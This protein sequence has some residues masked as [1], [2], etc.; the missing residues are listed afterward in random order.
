[1]NTTVFTSEAPEPIGPYSQAVWAGDLLFISGQ[2]PLHPETKKLITADIQIETRVVM[3]N[4]KAI[5]T[6]AGL[7]FHQVVKCTIF[8]ADMAQFAAVN[9]VYGSYFGQHPPAR[10]TVEVARLP[11]NARVEI[12][13]VAYRG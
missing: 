5:L 3:E 9:E 6:A 7:G 12:S 11:K 2:I 1:M 13:A 10:E 4:L 8:L